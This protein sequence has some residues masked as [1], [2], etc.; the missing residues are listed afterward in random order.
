MLVTGGAGFIGSHFVRLARERH[1]DWFVVNL[2]LL[3]Y[4][5]DL[6]KLAAV[7]GAGAELGPD[8]S[9]P[10][11]KGAKVAYGEPL[12]GQ[13]A[14]DVLVRGRGGWGAGAAAV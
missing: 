14:G 10:E 13:D 8:A 5:A 3:T 12:V 2:D 1:P 7:L 6:E 9:A 11:A 4:A